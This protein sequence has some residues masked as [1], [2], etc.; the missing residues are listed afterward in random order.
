MLKKLVINYN[1]VDLNDS[2]C[3]TL[4]SFENN[5]LVPFINVQI[6]E[7]PN[8][9]NGFVNYCYILFTAVHEYKLIKFNSTKK[10]HESKGFIFRDSNRLPDYI[11]FVCQKDEVYDLRIVCDESF[12]LLKEDSEIS[13]SQYL[14]YDTPYFSKNIDTKKAEHFLAGENIENENITMLG[15]KN[16]NEFQKINFWK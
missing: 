9:K 12:L 2:Y 5:L 15:I 14:P 16:I 1:Q 3:T 8:L 11:F 4:F 7:L 13:Q 6:E 10:I